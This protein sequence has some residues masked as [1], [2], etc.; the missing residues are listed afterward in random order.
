MLSAGALMGLCR[1]DAARAEPDRQSLIWSAEDQ[2]RREDV[3]ERCAEPLR[4]LA[5]DPNQLLAVASAAVKSPSTI[6]DVLRRE[7]ARRGL[8]ELRDYLRLLL[9]AA[10]RPLG[11][12]PQEP[13]PLRRHLTDARG[14]LSLLDAMTDP[15]TQSSL[16]R[17]RLLRGADVRRQDPAEPLGP[18]NGRLRHL[19]ELSLRGAQDSLLS[20]LSLLTSWEE[21]G[22]DER[23]GGALSAAWTEISLNLW[24]EYAAALGDRPPPAG[25]KVPARTRLRGAESRLRE[26]RAARGLER[27]PGLSAMIEGSWIT[28]NSSGCTELSRTIERA[29]GLRPGTCE[30]AP[31]IR[32]LF[33]AL[34]GKI[35]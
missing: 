24:F 20:A 22:L 16:R 34:L 11:D 26:L 7:A 14:L 10:S 8:G 32:T 33:E 27:L 21:R 35:S 3:L 9:R 30:E 29:R 18:R 1:L 17:G 12:Q 15:L 25:T 13:A 23:A 5:A 4:L 19:S 2:N 28:L 31:L 6:E